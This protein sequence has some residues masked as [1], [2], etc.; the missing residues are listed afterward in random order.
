MC[1]I[2]QRR[3]EGRGRPGHGA[4][5]YTTCTARHGA[6]K[7][8][9][10]PFPYHWLIVYIHPSIKV[11]ALASYSPLGLDSLS[12]L[13]RIY[14]AFWGNNLAVS[15]PPSTPSVL[16]CQARH[17]VGP[18]ATTFVLVRSEG[19]SFRSLFFF[20]F[21]WSIDARQY[22]ERHSY[23]WVAPAIDQA[24]AINTSSLSRFHWSLRRRHRRSISTLWGSPLDM[25]I[26]RL[27]NPGTVAL[28]LFFA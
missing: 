1:I 11:C 10:T 21:F 22:I 2:Y 6:A 19:I 7:Y 27:G 25:P 16:I 13:A 17:G 8:L 18:V 26:S 12:Q 28:C 5:W 4:W 20:F 3:K 24:G 9:P 15:I 14:I 23:L